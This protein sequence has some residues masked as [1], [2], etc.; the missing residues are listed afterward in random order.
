MNGGTKVVVFNQTDGYV[1]PFVNSKGQKTLAP[2]ATWDKTLGRSWIST[3]SNVIFSVLFCADSSCS[4]GERQVIN[5]E[6]APG[7][8]YRSAR[9]FILRGSDGKYTIEDADQQADANN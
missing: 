4:N 9:A 6:L 8:P 3:E 5:L 1:R 7:M 2:G